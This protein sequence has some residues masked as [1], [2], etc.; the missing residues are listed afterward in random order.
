M[1][2]FVEVDPDISIDEEDI[3]FLSSIET[4]LAPA[5]V[6]RNINAEIFRVWDVMKKIAGKYYSYWGIELCKRG[7][8]NEASS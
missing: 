2:Q 7:T 8:Y 1:A 6:E 3:W 4:E 5:K